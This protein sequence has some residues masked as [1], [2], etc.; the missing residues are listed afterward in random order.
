MSEKMQYLEMVQANI[1]RYGWQSYGIKIAALAL[2]MVFI[3]ASLLRPEIHN[4]G[5]GG[6]FRLAFGVALCFMLWIVDG[7]YSEMQ[8]RY[9][10]LYRN[11]V[12][13][14]TEGFQMKLDVQD[15]ANV[16]A[17]WRPMVVGYY[18]PLM[19]MLILLGFIAR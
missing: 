12:N 2:A 19:S 11:S 13:S 6:A 15:Q 8:T 10:D 9:A 7:H 1:R 18:V 17:I 5:S 4:I 3:S 14:L 16:G